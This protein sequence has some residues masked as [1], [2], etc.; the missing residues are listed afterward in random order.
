LPVI[1]APWAPGSPTVFIG[2]I[3]ALNS[4]STC[5]CAWGGVIQVSFA[6]TIKNNVS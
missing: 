3:P 1:P 2:G 6:G 5:N 4:M